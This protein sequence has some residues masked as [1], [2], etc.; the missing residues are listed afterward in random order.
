[1]AEKSFCKG[2]GKEIVWGIT[3]EGKRI[4][5][6]P[7]P[8]VYRLETKPDAEKTTEAERM[9]NTYVSHFAT[10]PQANRFS[11]SKKPNDGGLQ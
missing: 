3:S 5:L 10:C 8:P 7:K 1:M 11:A 4:P 6:D 9:A 2:C